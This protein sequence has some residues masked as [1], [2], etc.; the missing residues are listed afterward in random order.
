MKFSILVLPL[1][2]GYAA[3]AQG[4][5]CSGGGVSQAPYFLQTMLLSNAIFINFFSLEFRIYY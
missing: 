5:I 3:A 2:V 4:D 1:L